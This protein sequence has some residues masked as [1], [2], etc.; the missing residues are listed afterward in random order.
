MRRED[1]HSAARADWK[2]GIELLL[3]AGMLLGMNT[4]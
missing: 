1:R 3:L 2:H 4:V